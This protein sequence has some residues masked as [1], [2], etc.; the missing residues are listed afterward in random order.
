MNQ[1]C[2]LIVEKINDLVRTVNKNELEKFMDKSSKCRFP[3]EEKN[4]YQCVSG[5]WENI[6][7]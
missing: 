5:M 1:D 3:L 7:I 2:F 6:C 4:D